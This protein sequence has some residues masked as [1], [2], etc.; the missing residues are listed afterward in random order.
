MSPSR[1]DDGDLNAGRLSVVH[2]LEGDE[3]AVVV[4]DGRHEK[5]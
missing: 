3:K 5:A 4:D 1:S 2:F